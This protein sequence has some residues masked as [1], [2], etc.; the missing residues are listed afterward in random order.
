[1]SDLLE[2]VLQE[3]SHPVWVLRSVLWSS[4]KAVFSTTGPFL[5]HPVFVISRISCLNMSILWVARVGLHQISESR[6]VAKPQ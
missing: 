5:E 1:M 3:V 4:G 2:Q 6:S